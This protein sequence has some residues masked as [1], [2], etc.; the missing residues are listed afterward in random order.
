MKLGPS[1]DYYAHDVMH[2]GQLAT[3]KYVADQFG[4]NRKNKYGS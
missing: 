2:G 3:A 1:D 4:F